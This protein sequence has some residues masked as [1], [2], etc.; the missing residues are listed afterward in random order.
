MRDGY[1]EYRAR[2]LDELES[3][4]EDHKA[5]AKQVSDMRIDIAMLQVRSGVWG[6]IAGFIPAVGIAIY[7]LVKS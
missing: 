5:L 1:D 7:F 6:F 2:V 4:R 3:F